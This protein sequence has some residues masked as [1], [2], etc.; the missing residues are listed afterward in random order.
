MSSKITDPTIEIKESPIYFNKKWGMRET[1]VLRGKIIDHSGYSGLLALHDT[2][3][4][5][6]SAQTATLTIG[7][8][9][10]NNVFLQN[11]DFGSS[12]YLSNTDYSVTFISYPD[13]YFEGSGILT[14]QNEWSFTENKNG[15][16]SITHD[17]S[18][19]AINTSNLDGSALSNAKTFVQSLVYPSATAIPINSTL[20]VKDQTANTN[21]ILT[22]QSENLN[23]ITGEYSIQ[24][25]YEL[26]SVTSENAII[27]YT[28][29]ISE[30]ASGFAEADIS[31]TVQGGLNTSISDTETAYGNLNLKTIIEGVSG[32][33]LNETPVLKKESKD[34]RANLISFDYSFDDNPSNTNDDKVVLELNLTKNVGENNVEEYNLSGLVRGRISLKDSWERVRGYYDSAID[35]Y[36]KQ[37][38]LSLFSN[39]YDISDVN[40]KFKSSSVIRKSFDGVI[41]FSISTNNKS[42]PPEGFE[43]FEYTIDLDIPVYNATS[44]PLVGSK[45]IDEQYQ[46]DY[47]I[48]GLEYYNRGSLSINGFAVLDDDRDL[49]FGKKAILGEI[50]EIAEAYLAGNSIMTVKNITSNPNFG[51]RIEFQFSWDHDPVPVNTVDSLDQVLLV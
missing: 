50:T 38:V 41:E 14:P 42:D 34:E 21:F 33:T 10:R 1:I 6:Y 36:K 23:R 47:V 45:Y 2:I 11:I 51:K 24:E 13:T 8:F 29:N 22:N 26:D 25:T 30:S 40:T 5:Q 44:L 7:G 17:V 48:Q 28:I 18:A 9:T 31:G 39:Y 43:D 16:I 3:E 20:F 4:N 19:T 12:D 27:K 32:L 37:N 46:N 35:I 49:E 15:T